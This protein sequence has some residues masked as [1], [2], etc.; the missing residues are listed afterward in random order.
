METE[1]EGS[2]VMEVSFPELMHSAEKG[3]YAVGYF[4]SWNLDSLLAVCDAAKKMKSPVIIGFGG[5]F[6]TH[7]KRVVKDNLNIFAAIA[8]KACRNLSV[9]A[10]TIFNESN[11]FNAV[12]SSIDLGYDLVMFVDSTIST[13]ELANKVKKIVAKAH[14]S[15]VAVEAE[16]N[17]LPGFSV[18]T[19]KVIESQLTNPETVKRFVSQTGIDALSINIGQSHEPGKEVS[20]DF[21]RLKEIRKATKVP[22]VLHGGSN[23]APDEISKAIDLGVRK[24]NLGGV[25]K[26]IYFDTLKKEIGNIS[27]GYSYYEVVGSGFKEDILVKAR[28][29][30]QKVVE[31]YMQLYRSAGQADES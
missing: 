19:G 28:L 7:E 17:E 18:L 20:L 1:Q 27:D 10:C 22:L 29:K 13:D 31:K 15:V 26:K 4:E 8:K 9:P 25:L 30:V 23:L 3:N 21:E 12:L 24:F 2:E 6:L 5:I 16:I 14:S 11:D